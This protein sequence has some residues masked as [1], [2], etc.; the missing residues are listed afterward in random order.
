MVGF[1]D[2]FVGSEKEDYGT[3]G[4]GGGRRKYKRVEI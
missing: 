2:W 4:E 1:M 3:V